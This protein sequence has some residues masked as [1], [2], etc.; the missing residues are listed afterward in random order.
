[1]LKKITASLLAFIV[2]LGLFIGIPCIN[3]ALSTTDIIAGGNDAGP[4]LSWTLDSNG[5]LKIIGTGNMTNWVLSAYTPWAS[6]LDSI[7]TIDITDGVSSVGNDAFRDCINLTSVKL[8]PTIASI[9]NYSFLGCINLINAEI[10]L[11]ILNIGQS[12]L[13]QS[14]VFSD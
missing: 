1:M 5:V 11:G 7:V 4:T 12:L 14:L 10:P 3:F 2:I 9:G 13:Y 8:P 6:Y